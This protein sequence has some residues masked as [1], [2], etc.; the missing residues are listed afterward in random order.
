VAAVAVQ[1]FSYHLAIARGLDPDSP[2]GLT[3]IT[4]TL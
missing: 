2:K 3:K 1:L 4:S